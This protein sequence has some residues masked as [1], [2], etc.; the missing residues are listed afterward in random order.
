MAKC[1]RF[2]SIGAGLIAGVLLATSALGQASSQP[3]PP[4]REGIGPVTLEPNTDRP[5]SD[6][7][8]FDLHSPEA[9]LCRAACAYDARCRAFTYVQPGYQGPRPRCWLKSSVPPPGSH[10]C[11]VS[12][13]KQLDP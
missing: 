1:M 6:Y 8:D 2:L 4:N 13:V 9:E 5:G 3:P 12:G 11:C 10:A 7:T